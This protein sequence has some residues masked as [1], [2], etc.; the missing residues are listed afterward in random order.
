MKVFISHVE[1]DGEY[2]QR[3][4]QHLRA[5]GYEI[6]IN[7]DLATGTAP[8]SCVESLRSADLVIFLI[9]A[10][11]PEQL[12]SVW[13]PHEAE[14]VIS[15][16]LR[17]TI[18]VTIGS[19]HA[20]NPVYP[21]VAGTA[22]IHV[23]TLDE[24]LTD[25]LTRR[26]KQ[27][28]S[29]PEAT[30]RP[31]AHSG[32]IEKLLDR[33]AKLHRN[34]LIACVTVAA[35][36]WPKPIDSGAWMQ[37]QDGPSSQER[38]EARRGVTA[39]NDAL[40][41]IKENLALGEAWACV[42]SSSGEVTNIGQ[43]ASQTKAWLHSSETPAPLE[44]VLADLRGSV[45]VGISEQAHELEQQVGT[46]AFV[47]RMDELYSGIF[48]RVPSEDELE[49]IRSHA[50]R[51]R[52]SCP[53]ESTV[54]VEVLIDTREVCDRV[55]AQAPGFRNTC[56]EQVGVL[57]EPQYLVIHQ[58]KFDAESIVVDSLDKRLD[59][60]PK[61]RF[62][63]QIEISKALPT[64]SYFEAVRELPPSHAPAALEHD[65]RQQV[66][67]ATRPDEISILTITP[68][69]VWFIELMLAALL[70]YLGLTIREARRLVIE[71]AEATGARF[72]THL[73]PGVAHN[74]LIRAVV[75][76]ST[77]LPVVAALIGRLAERRLERI[78]DD[79]EGWF[80]KVCGDPSAMWW[81]E[82]A[83][84]THN[85]TV[86]DYA[87]PLI[88]VLVM[89]ECWSLWRVLERETIW[90]GLRRALRGTVD[91]SLR[92][93]DLEQVRDELVERSQALRSDQ[94]SAS[95][96]K[97][98][99]TKPSTKSTTAGDATSDSNAHVA[100][101]KTELGSNDEESS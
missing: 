82:T 8:L 75:A 68:P 57:D 90:T 34:L 45:F 67:R 89:R 31:G 56:L 91:A 12:E 21:L 32:M 86:L 49:D 88:V 33:A 94:A 54:M 61:E 92:A 4:G 59:K 26:V 47:H 11:A 79:V 95:T 69:S 48:G 15:R 20:R 6:E 28:G 3:L 38:C 50:L 13:L 65:L 66:R 14:A 22:S 30:T 41:I 35:V 78:D 83:G 27:L 18:V 2:V 63:Q 1:R 37:I 80:E 70:A 10:V 42:V 7:T 5:R 98:E 53:D 25:E 85:L 72:D 23:D 46:A 17:A 76:S 62:Q 73:W 36:Y 44:T 24:R 43:G 74:T 99:P 71:D 9:S 60:D 40:K 87:L 39:V 19:D 52:A 29:T 100:P 97:T 58:R 55:E 16:E 84:W 96:K 93:A 81:G 101:S 64:S 77:M 51:T